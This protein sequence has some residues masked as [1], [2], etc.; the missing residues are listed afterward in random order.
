VKS[1]GA[2]PLVTLIMACG[3]LLFVAIASHAGIIYSGP[4]NLSPTGFATPVNFD[5][6]SDG[7]DD[8]EFGT[9]NDPDI[10]D[11]GR[12]IFFKGLTGNAFVRANDVVVF[13]FRSFKVVQ[14]GQVID[15]HFLDPYPFA[16]SSTGDRN[17][18]GYVGLD[19]VNGTN[20]NFGWA[21]FSMTN[22][23]QLYGIDITLVDYAYE[24]V[25]RLG[26]M[27]GATNEASEILPLSIQPSSTNSM[28][29]SWGI[30]VLQSSPQIM[31]PYADMTNATPPYVNDP[32]AAQQLFRVRIPQ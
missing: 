26:I 31:G 7:T 29:L 27:A 1:F 17:L 32:S 2:K 6:N 20:T 28:I 16:V 10:I 18:N 23:G 30:G 4:V 21:H 15:S 19:L 8:F 22:N 11:D 25:P 13:T 5:L 12:E 14:A 24:T 3:L 9:T